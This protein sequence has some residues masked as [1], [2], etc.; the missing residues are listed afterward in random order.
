MD[1]FAYLPGQDDDTFV[2]LSRTKSG[3]MFRKHI[4]SKGTLNYPGVAGGK[5]EIDDKFLTTLTSN[6]KSKVCDIVQVPVAGANNEHTEDPFRNI[7]EV[8]DLKVENGKAYAYIDARDEVAASRLG[9]TLLGASAMLHLNYTDS[10]DGK[11]KGPTLLHVAVTN[12]PHVV[13]LDDFEN[14][15]ALSGDSS[16]EAVFLTAAEEHTNTKEQTME[17]DE[18][19]ASLK[20][21]HGIDVPA[22][23]L[24]AQS[25][26]TITEATSGAL[27]T[28]GVLKLSAGDTAST[29]DIVAGIAQLATDRVELTSKV[30]TLVEESRNASAT[31]R[32]ESLIGEGKILPKDKDAQV[33][34]LLS[35]SELFE[36]L[37]PEKPLVALSAASGFELPDEGAEDAITSEIARLSADAEKAGMVKLN[38]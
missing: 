3:T 10:R 37:V 32:V 27:S 21:D 38:A 30:D 35:N 2:A 23:Q 6:F 16:T 33:E 31:A 11:K 25:L 15:A 28:A 34:L 8:V 9:K 20:E 18:M 14:L 29:D 17:L 7:G 1:G 4:L 12:R 13:E 19:I 5:V 26:Q 22:L 36:K 24:S